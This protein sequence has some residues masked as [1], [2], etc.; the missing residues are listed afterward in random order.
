MTG[1][2]PNVSIV[3]V[4]YDPPGKDTNREQIILSFDQSTVLEYPL[5]IHLGGKK[6]KLSDQLHFEAGL[7]MFSGTFHLPNTKAT[8]IE[9]LLVDQ[10]LDRYCYDPQG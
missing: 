5:S 1:V 6:Y 7:S 10:V 8:C 4:L 3:E 9:L 2:L